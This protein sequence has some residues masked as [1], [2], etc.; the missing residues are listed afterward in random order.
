MIYGLDKE[1]IVGTEKMLTAS[2]FSFSHS[3]LKRLL[4]Q[5]L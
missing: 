3:V 2:I 4:T 5:S 1:N